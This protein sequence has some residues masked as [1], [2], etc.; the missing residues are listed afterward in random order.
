MSVLAA[1][2]A[3]ARRTVQFDANDKEHLE[4]FRMMAMGVET[5]GGGTRCQMHPTLRFELEYPFVDLRAMMMHK[6]AIQHLTHTG[7][8]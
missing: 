2:T 4:A 3:Q 8:M 5:P 7:I 1:I 6:V